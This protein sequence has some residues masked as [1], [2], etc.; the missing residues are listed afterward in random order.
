MRKK[1]NVYV[2]GQPYEV[3]VEEV[4]EAA[5]P[6]FQPQ[7]VAVAPAPAPV[8]VAPAAAPAPAP[9]A[10]APAPAPAAPAPAPASSAGDTSID[11][12]MP[13]N[14]IRFKVNQ[15]D[16]VKAGDVILILEAM[17]MENEVCTPVAGVIKTI[18]TP[19]GT[20]VNTGQKM[21]IIG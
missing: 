14:V 1:F 18:V 16:S 2:N 15:G 9:A 12:P 8:A 20:A 11:A 10:A 4:G 17:N 13:G 7:P 3:V 19:A 21:V 5:A 6:V